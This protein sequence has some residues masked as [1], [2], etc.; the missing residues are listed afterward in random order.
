[1]TTSFDGSGFGMSVRIDAHVAGGKQKE[2]NGE[3]IIAALILE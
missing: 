3:L 2:G 1:V